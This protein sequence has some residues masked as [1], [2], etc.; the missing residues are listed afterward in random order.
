MARPDFWRKMFFQL[1]Q[2]KL[3]F[4]YARTIFSNLFGQSILLVISWA[5]LPCA[6]L[7]KY[8]LILPFSGM[9]RNQERLPQSSLHVMTHM[10]LALFV[11]YTPL[12]CPRKCM[13]HFQ[14]VSFCACSWTAWQSATTLFIQLISSPSSP[15]GIQVYALTI[16]ITRSSSDLHI[17]LQRGA[18]CSCNPTPWLSWLGTSLREPLTE[19]TELCHRCPDS[20]HAAVSFSMHGD[21][22]NGKE[23]GGGH[24]AVTP[25]R[26]QTDPGQTC[27]ALLVARALL[28]QIHLSLNQNPQV[29]LGS[30][31]FQHLIPQSLHPGLPHPRQNLVLFLVE[32]HIVADCPAF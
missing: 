27:L 3:S 32:H 17:N 6:L 24:L 15:N 18:P 4:S 1:C 25:H 30:A 20:L 23:D 13:S 7:L 21:R 5:F 22:G 11:I 31:A 29:P 19:Q 9:S 10:Y 14:H 12:P 8:L 2:S 28:T 16:S 26:G